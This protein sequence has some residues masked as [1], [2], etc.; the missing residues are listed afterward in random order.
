MWGAFV[1]LNPRRAVGFGV[2]AIPASEILAWLEIH[3]VKDLDTRIELFDML[4]VLDDA[5]LELKEKQRE[6]GKEKKEKPDA[7]SSSGSG[8]VES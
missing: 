5:Y 7:D 4:L 3:Q 2:G 8:R 6:A 1:D